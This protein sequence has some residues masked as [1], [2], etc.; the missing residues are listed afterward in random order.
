[1]YGTVFRQRLKPGTT[2][3]MLALVQ[4]RGLP[5]GAVGGFALRS[6]ADPDEVWVMAVFESKQAYQK[7][8]GSPEQGAV[9]EK[10]RELLTAD[11]EWHDGE[12]VWSLADL[13]A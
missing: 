8:A 12:V 4:A 1:M 10:M 6:D 2:D 11:P 13:G 7:N 5:P 9:F 3:R